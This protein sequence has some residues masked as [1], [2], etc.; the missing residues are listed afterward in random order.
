MFYCY[1]NKFSLLLE[2]DVCDCDLIGSYPETQE[3]NFRD[4]RKD[5]HRLKSPGDVYCRLILEIDDNKTLS[6]IS[7]V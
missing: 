2:I 1:E 4:W 7:D 5:R 6:A 3:E